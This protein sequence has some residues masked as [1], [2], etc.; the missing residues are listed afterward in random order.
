MVIRFEINLK[1]N[2]DK[3][4]YSHYSF[5]LWLTL[6][7]SHP[8]FKIKRSSLLKEYFSIHKSL[9][10]VHESV[11]KYDLICNKISEQ[12]GLHISFEQ[13]ICLILYD[14]EVGIEDINPSVLEN[15]YQKTEYLFLQYKPSL[16]EPEINKVLS[17]LI[18]ER[19]TISIL[20]NTAF[21]RGVTLRKIL[22]DYEI[23]KYFSFQIYS[24]EVG[25]S[26]PNNK[27]FD[28]VFEEVMKIKKIER[29]EILH[30]GD[31]NFADYDG[32][33]EASFAAYLFR[34]K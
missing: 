15:L 18:K 7:K 5:D 27:I 4:S 25:F 21:I 8:D 32:A 33:L 22:E 31:N 2:F 26:K 10:E 3:Y 30:I 19:K 24:D 28:L 13:I 34:D 9:E 11:R 6:I 1:M 16:I 29:K 17:E 20:S 12:T 14:L 23:G